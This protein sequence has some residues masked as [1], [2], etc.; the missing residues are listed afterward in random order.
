MRQ[1]KGAEL[2]LR[3]QAEE[4]GRGSFCCQTSRVQRRKLLLYSDKTIYED[5]MESLVLRGSNDQFH[6]GEQSYSL[7][8]VPETTGSRK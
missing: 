3:W 6:K 7:S 2:E 4:T 1:I 5:P 8:D